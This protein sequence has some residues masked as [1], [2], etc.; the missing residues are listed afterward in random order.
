M[1]ILAITIVFF[2]V[3]YSAI[4]IYLKNTIRL[5]LKLCNKTMHLARLST[6]GQEMH[7]TELV[8]TK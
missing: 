1:R 3:E 7:Q 4:F 2:N 6:V 5:V 8:T